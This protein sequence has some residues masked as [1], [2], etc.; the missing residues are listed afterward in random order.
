VFS[1]KGFFLKIAPKS[2]KISTSINNNLKKIPEKG[3][4][5]S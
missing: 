4:L 2:Y 5:I 1:D 3:T